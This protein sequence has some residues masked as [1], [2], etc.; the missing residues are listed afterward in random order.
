MLLSPLLI[1]LLIDQHSSLASILQKKNTILNEW[2]RKN[3]PISIKHSAISYGESLEIP[4]VPHNIKTFY[5]YGVNGSL[6]VFQNYFLCD[7]HRFLNSCSS[8]NICSIY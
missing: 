1:T 2:F 4:F 5:K 6:I 3:F 7:H 8:E